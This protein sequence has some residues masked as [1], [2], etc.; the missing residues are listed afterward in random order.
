MLCEC[1]PVVFLSYHKKYT[2]VKLASFAYQSIQVVCKQ[3]CAK[4]RLSDVMV[5]R[6]HELC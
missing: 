3:L 6:K 1:N 4:Q 5:C 2:S